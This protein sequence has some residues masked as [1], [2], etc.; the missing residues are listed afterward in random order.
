M[1]PK[2][3][4]YWWRGL[5]GTLWNIGDEI[6]RYIVEYVAGRGVEQASLKEADLLAIGSVLGFSYR[7]GVLDERTHPFHVWGTGAMSAVEIGGL[8]NFEFSALRGP[9]T[10][11][12]TG[13][14]SGVT[15]GDPGILA[16]AVW[17]GAKEQTHAWGLIPHHSHMEQPWVQKLIEN[18]PDVLL[19]DVRDKDVAANMQKISSCEFIASTSLHG[20][21]LADSYKIPSI[22]LW[23]GALH[24]GGT[25]KFLDYFA[26]IERRTSDFTHVHSI[27]DL[28]QIDI[29]NINTRHFGLIDS[30]AKDLAKCFPL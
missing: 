9:L 28:N 7:R 12:L 21:V 17:E 14:K 24:P 26:G 22:W 15:Y 3:K 8:E 11:S 25:W 23:N 16:S 4:L 10:H 29:G 30:K 20:L 18:T 2:I 13:Y 5:K 1:K 6:N 19:I 27:S